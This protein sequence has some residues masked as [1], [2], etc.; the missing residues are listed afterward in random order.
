[1]HCQVKSLALID[2]VPF[3]NIYK[4]HRMNS[5]SSD[6]ENDLNVF[7]TTP[8]D[9]G[10]SIDLLTEKSKKKYETA[11]RAFMDWRTLNN[12]DSFSENVLLAYFK[13]LSE[14]YKSTSL[15]AHYSMLRSKLIINN[16]TNIENY[17]KLRAYLKHLS[18]GYQPKRA[19]VFTPDQI[20]K[21]I[22]EAPDIVYLATKVKSN[23]LPCLIRK[24]MF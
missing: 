21:F 18:E 9:K 16:G 3:S 19:K 12:F 8:D 1:M 7:C 5:D 11:Y 23:N 2:C 22:N 20:N 14:K 13:E 4:K 15:W 17:S 10:T 6:S 24:K